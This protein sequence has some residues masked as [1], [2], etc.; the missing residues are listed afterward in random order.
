[1]DIDRKKELLTFLLAKPKDQ[2][3]LFRA[4]INKE[5]NSRIKYLHER[6]K[7][8]QFECYNKMLDDMIYESKL[9]GIDSQ[10]KIL[11]EQIIAT[12]N[13]TKHPSLISIIERKL[14]I[15]EMQ[16]DVGVYNIINNKSVKFC[17]DI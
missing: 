5:L 8:D 9:K 6:S 3:K 11:K 12:E 15:V 2:P 4:I 17:I 10:T 14:Y 13:G 7:D 1:M 16:L